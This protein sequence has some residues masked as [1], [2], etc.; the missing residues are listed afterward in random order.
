MNIREDKGQHRVSSLK[1]LKL[2]V[3]W[4]LALKNV[5][6]NLF[7]LSPQV[8]RDSAVDAL[9]LQ[10][11]NRSVHRNINKCSFIEPEKLHLD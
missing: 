3:L 8:R 10:S 6:F 4:I 11:E 9:C 2:Y 5:F 1:N 7:F